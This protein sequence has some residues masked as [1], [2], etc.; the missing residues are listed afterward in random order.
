MPLVTGPELDKLKGE[1]VE[2]YQATRKM[3]IEALEEGYPYG[4]HALSPGEQLQRFMDMTP[5]E[6]Q[7][8]AVR[9]AERYRGLPNQN[10]LV[11]ADLKAYRDSM[12]GMMGGATR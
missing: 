5:E 10:E 12:A 11:E 6:T 7:H 3:L 1:L 2:W 8:M 9:L 4:S